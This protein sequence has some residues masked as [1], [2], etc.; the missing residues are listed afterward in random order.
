[1]NIKKE[2]QKYFPRHIIHHREKS[3]FTD[4]RYYI[5]CDK[6]KK[7]CLQLHSNLYLVYVLD[8]KT[9]FT[10][11][12]FTKAEKAIDFMRWIYSYTKWLRTGK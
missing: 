5:L 12:D 9:V 10:F 8:R 11:P 7:L 6:R 4:E 3:L 2:L 1:M